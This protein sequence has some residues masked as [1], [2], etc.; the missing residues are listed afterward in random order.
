M[1]VQKY[2]VGILLLSSLSILKAQ[3]SNIGDITI[4]PNTQMS[5]V[6]NLDNKS[7]GTIINDGVLFVYS[8]LNNDGVVDY[9][10]EG[11]TRFEGNNSQTISG[12]N[13]IYLYNAIFN[14]NAVQPAFKLSG[15]VSVENEV[16]F[17]NGIVNNEDFGGSFTFEPFAEHINTTDN[18][19]VDGQVIKVGDNS[20]NYPI[21]DGGYYRYAE[22]S[23]P[24][25]IDDVFTGKFFFT[26]PD[27]NYPLE[28]RT[29]I[30]ELI[31]NQEY[32]TITND[33][34]NSQ[35]VLT[36]SWDDDT[37]TPETVVAD[38]KTA[39]HIVRWDE[40]RQLWVDE[41]GVV[42][43][44]ARTVS[45]PIQLEDYGVFTLARIKE[46][47]LLPEDVVVYNAVSP[48]GDGKNDYFFI[49]NIQNLANN[50]LEV[51][52]R[53]GVKVFSTTNYDT[54]DNVFRG[55]SEGRLTIEGDLLPSGTY[56][57]VLTYD[58]SSNGSTQRVEQAGFLYL[59]AD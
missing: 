54:S 41:G 30:I 40:F 33:S 24:D 9:I 58:Y 35:I 3:T 6:N 34:G 16:N 17:N 14:N 31:D 56:F 20:F 59:N 39:I 2:L 4:T 19:Y 38:P 52:N 22:I 13:I 49:D 10:N 29:G 8:N 28:N 21:G 5:V 47:I 27:I 23:A 1:N 37:T 43:E 11:L 48:N 45:T 25:N 18:S 32:W 46:E 15:D 51:Y 57:Y 26:N 36:L 55:V 7:S 44:S 42:D 50:S 12:T 53:W